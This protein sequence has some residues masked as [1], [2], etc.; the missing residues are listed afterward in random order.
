MRAEQTQLR[1]VVQKLLTKV[2]S[3]RAVPGTAFSAA[4]TRWLAR[5]NYEPCSR[6]GSLFTRIVTR[7]PAAVGVGMRENC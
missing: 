5:G 1:P 7:A 3:D 6:Y 4:A 2:T